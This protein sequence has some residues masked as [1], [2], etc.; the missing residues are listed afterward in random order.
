MKKSPEKSDKTQLIIALQSLLRNEAF[1]TQEEICQALEKKG[2]DVTQVT[3]SRLINKLGAIKMNENHKMVYRL[4]LE[5]TSITANNQ[6][7]QL[8]LNISHNEILIVIRVSPG[9][10]QLVARLL[11]QQNHLGILGTIA[12]DDTIAVIP[13]KIAEIEI[14]L[15][16]IS[17]L[18]Y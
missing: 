2:F 6:L 4:P 12:G 1:E 9:S 18:L 16:N 17:T 3:I 10:A 15:K 14:V 11:D 13:E 8:V 7:R 5:M